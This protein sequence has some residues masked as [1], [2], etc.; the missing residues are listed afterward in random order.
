MHKD[1]DV[2]KA[3]NLRTLCLPIVTANDQISQAFFV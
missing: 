2:E 1:P 3:K